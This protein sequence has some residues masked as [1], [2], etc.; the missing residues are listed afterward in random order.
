MKK[1][2][3]LFVVLAT[4][5]AI[6]G[7]AI[8]LTGQEVTAAIVGTVTDPS[9]APIKGA[10]VKAT[11]TERG[12]VWSAETNDSGAYNLLRLP[13]G[14]YGV[15]VS[16]PG[17]DT[18]EWP[19]FTLV[20]N[21]T[22][23]INA[24]LKVGKIS[25]TVEV[26]AA[27]PVLQTENAEVGTIMDSASVT[28][29][30]LE[31]RNYIQLTLLSPGVVTTDPSTFNYGSQT[32]Q[33][34]LNGGGRPYI[35]GNREE[36]NN[37]LLDG[38]DNNQ[39][40]DN[41]TGY[42][43]SPDAIGE[44]NLITQNASSEFG[45]YAGGIINATIKS[46]T[47]NYHGDV[48]EFLRNDFF[49]A[50]KW[51]NSPY[52]SGIPGGLPTPKLRWNIF[53]GTFG[54]PIIKNKLFFFGDYQGVRR[55]L[56]A[57]SSQISVLTADE[58]G[59]N[60]GALPTQL[61]NPCAAGT[62]GTSG[63]ACNILAPS[64]RAAFAGNII[65]PAN[66]DPAF[67]ALVTSPLYPQAVTTLSNGFGAA[68]NTTNQRF[69]T[70]QGDI[71]VDYIISNRDHINARYSKADEFDPGFNSQ[72]LLGNSLSEA[73]LNNGTV[74]WTH[75]FSNNLLNE[76]RFGK[77][78][79]K[80]IAPTITFDP[81]VGNLAT[82]IGI[83]DGN[84]AGI[85]GLPEFGF[86]GGTASSVGQQGALTLLGSIVNP[87][88]FSSTVTQFDE[89]LIY[90]RGRHA[91]KAG[92]QLQRYNLNVFYPGNAGELGAEVFGLGAGGN[93]S[94]NGSATGLGDPS[95]DFAL[96]LP[97]SV[98]RGVST[99][100]WHAR[101]WLFAGFVQ[102]D[103]R[104]TNDLTF[105]IGL[106]Y[107]NRTPWTELH[108]RQV[109]VN[110]FTGALQFPGSDAVPTGVVGT[111]GFSNGLYPTTNG[112][113][114]FEPRLGFAWSPALWQGKTV[115]RGGFAISSYLEGTGTNLRPTQNPPF[116]PSQSAATNTSSGL[117][118]TTAAAF[119]IESAFAAA[120]PPAGDPFINSTMLTWWNV[121][122]AVADQWNLTI[123]QELARNTTFQIGYVGQRTTH[124]MV[125]IDLDQ[126]D[127][128]ADGSITYPFIGG[129]NP[130]GTVIDGIATTAPT[131]GPN[132]LGLVKESA[133]VG[134]MNYNS[135]QAVLQKRASHGLEAQVSYTYQKCMANSAGYYGSWGGQSQNADSYWQNIFNPNGDYAQCYWDTKHVLSAYAVYDLPFGKGKQFGHNLPTGVNAVVGNWALNPIVSWHGGFPLNLR[136]SDESGTGDIFSPRPNCNGSVSYPKSPVAG[137]GLQWFDPTPFSN[138]A[139]GSFGNCPSQGPVIG[140]GYVDTDLSLQKNVPVTEA[141]KVQFRVDFFNLFNHTNYNA[142]DTSFGD[143]NFGRLSTSQDAR[144]MQFALKFYF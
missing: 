9:G 77:N 73:W 123:Q 84:P 24:Q 94:G 17:F 130:V 40:S 86:D 75:S 81:S 64:A 68:V 143:A 56:P 97:E 142:P 50:N 107:E 72:P 122:P 140:P 48:F 33:G 61:Y 76:V 99:G 3:C 141:M 35:N 16:A 91:I 62:G 65:S 82:K 98:G 8:P 10:S 120:A 109:N 11:D 27:A 5:A 96:G 131:Y 34:S 57:S 26:S 23:R 2:A 139:P 115:I 55:D 103:W 106:R 19:P 93:Y 7:V 95:A 49:N 20:L 92:F 13:V 134:N 52:V 66:L 105:N 47:N 31:S 133:S 12:T 119:N 116:T 102:D 30:A 129:L 18:T 71:K 42:T 104:V 45:N 85:A 67:T 29:L 32:T 124:L 90:T 28:G 46:G 74:N 38:V 54:G 51:E 100:G 21:Q 128:H 60:F 126:G 15:R 136:G 135:L 41:L 6:A 58:I 59:G 22:A 101:D 88:H 111:N 14:T 79:I 118:T 114:D 112:L 37:F 36:D 138:P 25:E 1:L 44:F 63:T 125:P 117:T 43:P 137:V 78:G 70:D 110:I 80:L 83:L 4:M 87:Q 53:G 108:N 121:K 89:S 39:A 69:N 127:L 132:G 144:E 113:L